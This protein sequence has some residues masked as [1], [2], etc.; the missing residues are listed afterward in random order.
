MTPA[1]FYALVLRPCSSYPP[2]DLLVKSTK[3]A[4]VQIMATFGQESG[5]THRVQFDGGPGHS[6]GM[7]ELGTI[8]DVMGNPATDV[9]AQ[10]VCAQ[11]DIPWKAETIYDAI[12]WND[13]LAF[14]FARLLLWAD[15]SPLPALGDESGGWALY[16][17]VWRPGKP[18]PETWS[19]IYAQS[20]TLVTA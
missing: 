5:W 15:P 20:L 17:R 1:T 18:R 7:F 11:W 13:P 14:A 16:E 12:T 6:W 9:L 19:A 4:L 8:I 2:T 3:P 10:A